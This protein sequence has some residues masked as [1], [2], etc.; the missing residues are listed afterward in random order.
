MP[1]P[2]FSC[3]RLPPELQ[4][5]LQRLVSDIPAKYKRDNRGCAM[6]SNIFHHTKISQVA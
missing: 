6:Y 3:I 4:E 5:D 2:Y 1:R